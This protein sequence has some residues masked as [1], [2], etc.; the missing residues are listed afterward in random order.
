MNRDKW[1]M[2][3][4]ILLG[5]IPLLWWKPGYIFAKG[6]HFPFW[7]NSQ[8][9]F[10]DDTYLWSSQNVGNPSMMSSFI[11]NGFIWFIL[12][13]LKFDAG[14]I[15][16]IF[17]VFFFMGSGFF[18]YN[19][20]KTVYP[21]LKL[22]PL[23]SSIFYMFNFFV[24][25]SRLNLGFTWAYTLLPLLMTLL[26]KITDFTIQKNDMKTNKYI[27]F[28]CITLTTTFSL[29]SVNLVNIVIILLVLA[30]IFFYSLIMHR[31]LIRPLFLSLMKITVLSLFLNIWWVVPALNY[32]LWSSTTLNPN[33]NVIS[34][35]WTHQRASFLNLFW[36]NG[37]WN[38]RPEYYPYYNS[39]SNLILVVLN[40]F[41]MI[42]ASSA[43]L[44][45][46]RESHFNIYTMS[47]ILILVFLAKGLHE[48]LGLLNLLLY[49]YIPGMNM[50]REPVSKFTLALTPLLSLLIGYSA[51]HIVDIKIS[52]VKT[53]NL[54]KN[55]ATLLI[56][57]TF[58]TATYPL[59]TNPI[60]TKTQQLP[61]SSYVKIP[62]YWHQAIEWLNN[63]YGDYKILITPLDDF[64]QIP[65]AWG[66][67]GTDQFLERMINKPIISNHYQY[68]YEINPDTALILRQLYDIIKYN[69]TDEFRALLDLLNI[70]YILQR[71]DVLH[72]FTGRKIISPDEMQN[73]LMQQPYIRLAQKFGQLDIYEYI[74]PKPYIYILE[75]TMLQK[76]AIKI[77]NKVIDY[78]WEFTSQADVQ[79]WQGYTPKNQFGSEQNL[80]H[81]RG[82]LKA[83]LWNS[84]WGWKTINSP[85]MPA[86]YGDSYQI[87]IDMKGQNVHQAHINENFE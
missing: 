62:D 28:F 55:L 84:T 59:I 33:V 69:R 6:D 46:R 44:V 75:N 35:S 63:Q 29:A 18:M 27:L 2:A 83:E 77:E 56:I 21:K 67:Y 51:D 66:Y 16:I 3:L 31:N 45:R 53:I 7:L 25:K 73:F 32:Y 65:Y 70:K 39:Y 42:L 4:L 47:F 23:F 60:E 11:F 79:E 52:R 58:I 81:D 40:F 13:A 80:S 86:R 17:Q 8:M 54:I 15:Q 24:L 57:S 50:F 64:Y 41:P 82:T 76:I 5:A 20:S 71:N 48:P 61:F 43:I 38:W 87:R 36:L 9:I 10:Y 37:E 78:A 68:F 74:A 1:G 26:I 22:S 49:K 72:N 12:L 30:I 34:W 85:L 19:L 14:F